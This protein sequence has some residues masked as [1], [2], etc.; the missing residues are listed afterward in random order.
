MTDLIQKFSI[1]SASSIH[2]RQTLQN[3]RDT[4]LA[5]LSEKHLMSE[6]S[7]QVTSHGI[8]KIV[9]N[10]PL[11]GLSSS[12]KFELSHDDGS[13]S[14][15]SSSL[16]PSSDTHS[17]SFGSKAES[18][19]SNGG[20][21]QRLKEELAVAKCQIA[22]MDLEI[23][24]NKITK[25]TIDQAFSSPSDPNI[26]ASS[27]NPDSLR[28]GNHVS[29]VDNNHQA[30][31]RNA[32]WY[33]NDYRSESGNLSHAAVYEGSQASW[34]NALGG[35][36]QA[37]SASGSLNSQSNQPNSSQS[38]LEASTLDTNGIAQTYN[39]PAFG[40]QQHSHGFAGNRTDVFNRAPG[41][42]NHSNMP[43]HSF[44]EHEARRFPS[45][46]SRPNSAFGAKKKI[47][48][49]TQYPKDGFV[50]GI[51]PSPPL[52]PASYHSSNAIPAIG[53]PMSGCARL[54]PTA[55]EFRNHNMPPTPWN[56]QVSI[57]Y[58]NLDRLC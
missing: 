1:D 11:K 38:G 34:N 4:I 23:S 32:D 37:M 16:T 51:S 40:V 33:N 8:G 2:E 22:R 30:Y 3:T 27:G 31:H 47:Q 20:E 28:A 36:W 50:D 39:Q 25:H 56:T 19:N 55:V 29:L 48:G 9:K 54:S 26:F 35:S 45:P 5:K 14:G 7:K 15:D 43:G 42:F 53:R 41:N 52:T 18:S 13:F 17:H 57:A 58:A 21:L 46:F 49:W 44:M 12:N 10:V 24:Q 6:K